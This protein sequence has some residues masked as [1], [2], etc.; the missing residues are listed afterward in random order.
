MIDFNNQTIKISCPE[1]K[2][3]ITV[4]L[5]QVAN[6]E[7]VKCVCGQGIHL[8]DNNKSAKK[9]IGDMNKSFKNLENIFKKLK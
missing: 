6:E 5:E 7:I 1:C 3:S 4:S 9:S 2:R 8:K